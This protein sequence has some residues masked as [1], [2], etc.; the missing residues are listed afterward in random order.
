MVAWIR[1]VSDGQDQQV[2]FGRPPRSSQFAK[3]RSGN[4]RGRPRRRKR[5]VPYDHLLGQ[6][7]T[8]REDSRERRVTAAEA[9][10]LQLTKK[11]LEGCGPS[12]RASLASIERAREAKQAQS[13]QF[14][15]IQVTIRLFGLCCIVENFGMAVRLYP[16]C[17][18][19]VRLELKPWIVQAALDRMTP[20]HLSLDEQATVRASVRSPEKVVWP[21]WWQV[22]P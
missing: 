1:R 6:M 19:K 9:F 4:P 8:I 7:V 17:S 22:R 2:G 15:D 21:Q 5:E 10:I 12:A 14:N 16:T 13:D 3:G 20:N 18:E 11:G